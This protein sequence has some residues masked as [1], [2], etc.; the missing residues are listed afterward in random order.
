MLQL[1]VTVAFAQTDTT[2]TYQGELKDGGALAN[3]SFAM[4]FSLWNA[5]SSG[6]QIG[7][8]QSF[9]AV[10]VS[11]GRFTVELDF[12]T[13]AFNNDDR[14]LEI[15]VE[16]VPLSPRQ[17][18]TRAPY[19]MQTRG[20]FVD[21]LERVGIGTTTPQSRL[22]VAGG[23]TLADALSVN[24]SSPTE[25][26]DVNGS[27]LSRSRLLAGYPNYFFWA[28][29]GQGFV[30][31]GRTQ[32]V[33]SSEIF[34]LYKN[35]TGF[36]G[37]YSQTAAS[38]KPFYGYSAGG[39]VDAY[40]YFDGLSNEWRLWNGGTRLIVG[41]SGLTVNGS[42]QSNSLGTNNIS[43]GSLFID[44]FARIGPVDQFDQN[45][46]VVASSNFAAATFDR[47]NGDGII[48]SLEKNHSTVGTISVDGSDVSYNS[49]TGSHYAW[50]D[51]AIDRGMLVTLTGVNRH[52]RDD[53]EAEI[54]YGIARTTVANDPGCLGAYRSP[55][56]S[57]GPAGED[58]LHLVMSVGNGEM[59]VTDD[60]RG[61]IAPGDYLVSSDI[62]GYAMRDDP[63][64]FP[65]GHVIARA[66]ERVR[67]DAHAPDANG[68]RRAKISV[69]FDASRRG[70]DPHLPSAEVS[71]L[72]AE[73]DRL[74]ARLTRLESMVAGLTEPN[75]GE[76]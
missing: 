34:G 75:Q 24:H 55:H 42:L 25:M 63:A 31:V 4:D 7:S 29:P 32:Q 18:I 51:E 50:T 20:I 40:H 33:T 62:P 69:L 21:A 61:D 28:D 13:N 27:I 73:N 56:E 15:V 45:T 12:G 57:T 68:V 38:G 59:W 67:W 47:T 39:D 3:G 49:F 37:M 71:A 60:G 1:A 35:T 2:F 9:S 11:D 43:T 58:D 8:I 46:L 48:V 22:D 52:L 66:A 70:A 76:E 26:I 10:S 54:I 53:P 30:G 44:S 72:L 65:I 19:A 14:W 36:S 17:P 6:S 64:R 16:G 23:A 41:E 5:E 74:R